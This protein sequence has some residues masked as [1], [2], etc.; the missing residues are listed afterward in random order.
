M[1]EK[2][3]YLF[4]I[5]VVGEGGVGKTAL[6]MRFVENKFLDDY[7]MTIGVDFSI[8]TIDVP[9]ND[10][11]R[12]VKLQIWDTGGQERFS[13][14]RP[15]YYRGAVGGLVVFDLTDRK[16][17]EN[18]DRWFTEVYTTCV[19]VPLMLVGNKV[20]LPNRQVA[21]EEGEKLARSRNLPYF[22]ASAKSAQN[23]NDIFEKLGRIIVMKEEGLIEPELADDAQQI[24]KQNI[25]A[26]MSLADRASNAIAEQKYQDA[27]KFLRDA[28]KYAKDTDYKDGQ[29]WIEEQTQLILQ[30]LRQQ[31]AQAATQP[32]LYMICAYCNTK[33]RVSQIGKI[34]CPRCGNFLTSQP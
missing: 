14:T 16:T 4:K 15:L 22:E 17:F 5:I 25:E 8:K 24:Y 7:K 30:I 10:Q 23:V 2:Y 3:D 29:K 18:L 13:Y 27:L 33:Y 12:K 31:K 1:S 11:N 34:K 26:Y 9:I 32:S 28:Y 21:L 19:S 20:D 6:L